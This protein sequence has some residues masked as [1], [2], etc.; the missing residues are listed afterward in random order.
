MRQIHWHSTQTRSDV[1][2]HVDKF[3]AQRFTVFQPTHLH[4]IIAAA[5][6]HAFN[7]GLRGE[8]DPSIFKKVAD[9]VLVPEFTPRSGIKI[10]INENDPAEPSAGGKQVPLS[11]FHMLNLYF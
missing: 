3:I 11:I 2:T 1:S 4:Y 5:N 7:Y 9:A 8:T 6:L 10:Q